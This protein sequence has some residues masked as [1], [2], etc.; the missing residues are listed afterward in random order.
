MKFDYA[1]KSKSNSDQLNIDD[2]KVLLR[3]DYT[4]EDNRLNDLINASTSFIE[5]YC[6]RELTKSEITAYYSNFK[7]R[8]LEIP[9]GNLI[10]VNT[11]QYLD[12][13]TNILTLIDESNYIVLNHR[14]PGEIEFSNNFSFPSVA[15]RSDAVQIDYTAGYETI[16]DN[17]IASILFY[18]SY[19]YDQD[20]DKESSAI[21]L[22]NP[23][24][25]YL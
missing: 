20:T 3:I 7:E 4:D 16:P 9:R 10:E 6:K 25:I 11:V 13:N 23:Y 18:A 2:L 24:R 19:L 22:A 1:I 12:Y 17:L 8:N 15:S 21:K 5:S 14:I